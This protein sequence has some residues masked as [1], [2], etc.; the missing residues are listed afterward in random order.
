MSEEVY[1][2][3]EEIQ[4]EDIYNNR[5]SLLEDGEITPREEGF[6]KGYAEDKEEYDKDIDEDEG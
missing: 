2:K 5:E 4:L 1:E 3:Q 6:M